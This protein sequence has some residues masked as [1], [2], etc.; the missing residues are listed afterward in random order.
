MD[1][2]GFYKAVFD[3][4]IVKLKVRLLAVPIPS[5]LAYESRT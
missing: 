2:I 3:L 5:Y 4:Q 1:P